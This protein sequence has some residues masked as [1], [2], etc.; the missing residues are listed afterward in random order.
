[1]TIVN[2]RPD[3]DALN[4]AERTEFLTQLS[5]SVRN[6]DWDKDSNDWI[7]REELSQLS[8]L[9]LT[10]EDL[11]DVAPPAK[12]PLPA[13]QTI[14]PDPAAAAVRA[15]SPGTPEFEVFV[16]MT[17][18]ADKPDGLKAANAQRRINEN[19]TAHGQL[20]VTNRQMANDGLNA[21]LAMLWDAVSEIPDGYQDIV[22]DW[23]EKFRLTTGE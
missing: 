13:P 9:G 20:W 16:W 10:L 19:L 7:L 4:Q 5:N 14:R 12:P 3:L 22:N 6:W 18:E 15:L 1:M 8:K 23:R 21:A 11:P 2:S 17:A